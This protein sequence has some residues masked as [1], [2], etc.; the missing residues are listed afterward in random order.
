M[1]A[2]LFAAPLGFTRKISRPRRHPS[3]VEQ[4]RTVKF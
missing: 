2:A 4:V 1:P 3:E